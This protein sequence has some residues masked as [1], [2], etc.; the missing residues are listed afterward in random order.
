MIPTE[1]TAQ[2]P[3]PVDVVIPVYNE[4]P[5]A[6]EATLDACLNQTYSASRIFLVDD[7][8]SVPV[9]IS[10]RIE[11]TGRVELIRLPQNGGISKARNIGIAKSDAALIACVNSEILPAPDWVATCASHLLEHPRVGLCYTRMVPHRPQRLLTRW[12][13]R[14]QEPKFGDTTKQV[15]FAPGHAIMA[16]CEALDRVGG[17]TVGMRCDEDSDICLRI[18]KAGWETH[19]IAASR[20]VS[21]QDDSLNVLAKKELT[22][23]DWESPEDYPLGRFLLHRTKWTTVRMAR[24]LVKGRLYFL[25]VDLAVSI[26]AFKIATERTRT[27]RGK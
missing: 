6:I 13:M 8:S 10:R 15:P 17:F 1:P 22:R 12:R 18:A 24:N 14:F 19:Y 11:I 2:A 16:R 9:S 27:A 7:G 4:R 5:D 3:A 20:C 25:P 21:I 26:T 23:S